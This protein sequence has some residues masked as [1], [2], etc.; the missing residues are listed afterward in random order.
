MSNEKSS[1]CVVTVTY[2][3]RKKYLEQVINA[4]IKE[5]NIKKILVVD[6]ASSC[7][8]D[9]F[10]SFNTNKID[11]IR[12]EENTGSA[13]GYHVGI[14]EAYETSG[15]EFVWLLDDDNVPEKDALMILLSHYIDQL[16]HGKNKLFAFQSKRPSFSTQKELFESM[17]YKKLYENKNNFL[18]FSIHRVIHKIKK[19]ILKNN[20]SNVPY[21]KDKL[22]VN[23]TQYGGL[24]LSRN[25]IQNIGFPKKT[26]FLYSDDGEYTYRITK[27]GGAICIIQRSIVQDVDLSW[28]NDGTYR[29]LFPAMEYNSDLKIYYSVRNQCYFQKN[30]LVQNNLVFL[31]NGLLY[32]FILFIY[33][34]ISFKFKRFGLILTAIK[35]G[36]T[37]KLGKNKKYSFLL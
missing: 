5:E 22:F 11:W 3:N 15:C 21:L 4:C 28:V 33:S 8:K 26:F 18:G 9:F 19:L 7:D 32:V 2:G 16:K 10:D 27:Q 23:Y 20:I 6:N 37:G 17:K 36:L 14:K 25:L 1:V 35:D 31:F 13:N 12:L 29:S 34:C 24:L 30:F